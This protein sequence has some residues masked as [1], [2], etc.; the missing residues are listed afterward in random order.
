MR[1]GSTA[2][3]HR[4]TERGGNQ[5]QWMLAHG[6][7]GFLGFPHTSAQ[8]YTTHWNAL[9]ESRVHHHAAC[10]DVWVEK[11]NPPLHSRPPS[12]PPS[13]MTPALLPCLSPRPLSTARSK[14]NKTENYPIKEILWEA[15]EKKKNNFAG[16]LASLCPL[17][18]HCWPLTL[19]PG[20]RHC[21]TRTCRSS[22]HGP[23]TASN[24]SL[25]LHQC[26]QH[27]HT[28]VLAAHACCSHPNMA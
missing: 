8:T 1:E 13:L 2:A 3:K 24:Q 12:T 15:E 18:S 5:T 17:T 26:I 23:E 16:G 28:S 19:S 11:K 20:R 9:S 27:P 25:H 14:F 22:V 4:R 7:L 21:L 10:Q 6:R